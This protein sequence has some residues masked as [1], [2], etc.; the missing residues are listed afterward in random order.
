[1]WQYPEQPTSFI[2]EQSFFKSVLLKE[3]WVFSLKL[4]TIRQQ[5]LPGQLKLSSRWPHLVQQSSPLCDL[6]PERTACL[7]FRE[8]IAW[9]WKGSGVP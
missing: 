7:H 2:S 8:Q 9:Q 5:S 3:V 4:F 1:M 6:S